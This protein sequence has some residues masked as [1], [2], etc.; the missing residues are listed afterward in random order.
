MWDASRLA[1]ALY[2]W[3]RH[4]MRAQW[5]ADLSLFDK[6]ADTRKYAPEEEDR[7][8]VERIARE[9]PTRSLD[10]QR[11]DQ[12]EGKERHAEIQPRASRASPPSP[13]G[14][15]EAAPHASAARTYGSGAVGT[16]DEGASLRRR[17]GPLAQLYHEQQ[18]S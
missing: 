8:E 5:H 9:A 12:E 6:Y 16:V 13:H 1:A 14:Q 10:S 4:P 17:Q 3:S 11:R 2:L 7:E 18:R 15:E